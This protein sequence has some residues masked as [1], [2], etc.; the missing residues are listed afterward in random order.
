MDPMGNIQR[1]MTLMAHIMEEVPRVKALLRNYAN[2][3]EENRKK[4]FRNFT[5]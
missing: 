2:A 5:N 4:I 1:K 3:M